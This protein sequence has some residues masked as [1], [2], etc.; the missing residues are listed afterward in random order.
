[1]DAP[2]PCNG[3]GKDILLAGDCSV[4]RWWI[5]TRASSYPILGFRRG[6]WRWKR[7][8]SH[9]SVPCYRRRVLCMV[10]EKW[11]QG[12]TGLEAWWDDSI[13][14]SNS[15]GCLSSA[16]WGSSSKSVMAKKTSRDLRVQGKGWNREEWADKGTGGCAEEEEDGWGRTECPSDHARCKQWKEEDEE[17]EEEIG[18]GWEEGQGL[19]RQR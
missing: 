16:T 13:S 8:D 5:K 9:S 3:V 6:A 18:E 14:E 19:F 4:P 15:R 2:E 12:Q 11:V 10:A 7:K 17:E 1:M